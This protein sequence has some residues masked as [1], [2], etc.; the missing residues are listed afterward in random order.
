ME[1]VVV[2]VAAFIV[3]SIIP[4]SLV[5]NQIGLGFFSE[6]SSDLQGLK[7]DLVIVDKLLPG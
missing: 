6:S 7:A 2:V 5:L 3:T 1:I 4:V